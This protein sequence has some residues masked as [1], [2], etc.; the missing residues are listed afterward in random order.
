MRF[1][2]SFSLFIQTTNVAG[3][4]ITFGDMAAK[5]GVIHLIDKV[6]LDSFNFVLK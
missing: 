2:L 4:I 3:G 6:S 5:N 1:C